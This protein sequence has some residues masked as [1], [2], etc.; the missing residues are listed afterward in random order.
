MNE[1]EQHARDGRIRQP[2][3][4]DGTLLRFDIVEEV[5]RL[6]SEQPWQADHTANTLVK[7]SDLRIVLISLKAGA[8]LHEH[9]TAGRLAIQALSGE[10]LVH[11]EAEV[12]EMSAGKLLALDRDVLHEIEAKTDSVFLLTIVWPK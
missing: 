11:V 1:Y 4:T 8:R 6:K 12:I 10:I 9:Q 5:S 7:Y 3:A 2:V